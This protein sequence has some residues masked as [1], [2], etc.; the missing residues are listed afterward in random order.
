MIVQHVVFPV[1]YHQFHKNQ[2]YN[3]I[4]NKHRIA[5]RLIYENVSIDRSIE[6]EIICETLRELNDDGQIIY[7][8]ENKWHFFATSMDDYLPALLFSINY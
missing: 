2:A 1:G 3:E 4:Y 5:L 7:H 8:D 6:H